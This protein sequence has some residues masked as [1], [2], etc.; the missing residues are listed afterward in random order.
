MAAKEVIV[1][2]LNNLERVAPNEHKADFAHLR[3]KIVYTAPELLGLRWRE[4]YNLLIRI[5]PCEKDTAPDWVQQ[6][7]EIWNQAHK[8]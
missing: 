6:A 3:S 5:T 4:T 1:D 2:V 7:S 8:G